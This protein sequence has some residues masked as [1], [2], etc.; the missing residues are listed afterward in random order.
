MT[1]DLDKYGLVALTVII[2]L[3]LFIA[4]SDL[5]SDSD[6]GLRSIMFED[7]VSGGDA[8]GE[9]D[10]AVVV[11]GTEEDARISEDFD[12]MEPPVDV[13]ESVSGPRT[14]APV[15]DGTFKIHKVRKG[16]N[17]STISRRY[18]GKSSCWERISSANPDV[19]ADHLTVG[20]QLRIPV[21]ALEM[22][23]DERAPERSNAAA[24][25]GMRTSHY[26]VKKGDTL[27]KI[28]R[29]FYGNEGQW[30]KIKAANRSLIPDTKKLKIGIVLEIPR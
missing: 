18:Y 19:N 13:T 27:G 4:I 2:V 7:N 1:S 12:F 23:G 14:Q 16:E 20:Q 22:G 3:I 8:E 9:D 24:A 25:N 30:R 29:R 11:V 5:Q 10:G 17:L 28:A 21:L 6:P 15:E 26:R